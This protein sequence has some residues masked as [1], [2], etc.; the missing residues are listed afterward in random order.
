MGTAMDARMPT[1]ATV[2]TSSINVKPRA[3]RFKEAPPVRRW[4]AG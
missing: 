2:T 1:S 3:R 4:T